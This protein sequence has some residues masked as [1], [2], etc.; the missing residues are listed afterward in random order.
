M[1]VI[2]VIKY[3]GD[4][5]TFIWKYPVEDFNTSSQLVVHESQE[6]IFFLNGQALDSFGPG[7]HSLETSN[8]PLINKVINLPSGGTSPFH[9]EVYFIN[10]VEQMGIAWGTNSRVQFLEPNY[11]FPLSVGASGEMALAIRNGRKLLIKLVGTEAILSQTKLIAYFKAFLQ[12]KIKSAVAQS[13]QSQQICI[14]ETDLKLD[15]LSQEIKTRLAPIFEEYGLELTQLMVTAIIKPEDD[16]IYQKFKDLYFRQYAD[17]RE[18]EINQQVAIVNQET[19]AKRTIIEAQAKANKRAIEG[20]TYHQERSFD[21]AEKV[22]SNEAVGEF[23]NAG[24]GMGVIAGVGGPIGS[25]VST[26]MT[27]AIRPIDSRESS[28]VQQGARA[29][30]CPNCGKAFSESDLFCSRCGTKRV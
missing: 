8:I 9:A 18:S 28:P 2:D 22:A 23:A 10:L 30:F 1:T 29:A 7:R 24:I 17:I 11:G 5:Q 26:A 3:E 20:Y 21:V 6:A 19:E 27:E 14:F 13:I 16:P 15:E 25:T 4:N 12:T